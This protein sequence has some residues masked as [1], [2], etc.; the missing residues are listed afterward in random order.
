MAVVTISLEDELQKRLQ[1]VS[2]DQI[3]FPSG[4]VVKNLLMMQERQ[5]MRV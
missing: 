1:L 5:E 4:S 3:G 2:S